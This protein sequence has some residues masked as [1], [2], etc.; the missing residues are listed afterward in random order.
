[1]MEREELSFGKFGF[2]LS[3]CARRPVSRIM[4]RKQR[5][6]CL[7]IQDGV[8]NAFEEKNCLMENA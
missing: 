3:S 6:T 2:V 4:A 5:D 8:R 1:M 7:L